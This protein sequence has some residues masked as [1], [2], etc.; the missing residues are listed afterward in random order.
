[1]GAMTLVARVTFLVLVG[2][3]FAAFFVAQRLKSAPPV[4]DVNSLAQ[5]LLAQRRRQARRATTSAVVL[6]VA[7]DVDG[8][9][10]QPRRRPGPAARRRRPVARLP[11]AAAATGTAR[12]TTAAARPTASTGCAS[13]CATRAARRSSQQ[14]MNVDTRAPRSEVCIGFRCND[15]RKRM[16]N[17]ISQGDRPVKIYIKGVSPRYATQFRVLRTDDGKPREV[18]RFELRGGRAPH[19][20]GRAASTASRSP[21]GTYIVQSEVRDTAGNVGVTP[22]VLEVGADIP[23]RPGLTVRGI[24]AQPPLRPVTAGSRVEFRVDARGA[25][26]R[27]R[28]RRVGRLGGAQAR[29]GETDPLLAF[30]APEGAVGRLPARAA[31]RAAGTRPCRSSSRRRARS[32]MLVV[33]PTISWLGHRQGRRPAVRR[34]PELAGRRRHGAL[35]ARVRRRGRAAGRVR[36][37]RRAAARLPRPPADPL[38]PDER[39]RPR[40]HAQPARQRPRGRAAARL[41]ALGDAHARPPPA[42]LR[43]RRR[44]PGRDR[45]RQP[46]PRRAAARARVRGRPGR[47]RAPRSRPRPTRSARASRACARRR[48]RSRSASTRAARRTG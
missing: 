26:Y 33:V 30:R 25:P 10:R 20:L 5:L 28:V 21:P 8:R 46:A 29:H 45:R 41:A 1:M 23:G 34:L 3:T 4:I 32:S 2:A 9:R 14:T 7:D 27:W 38:R 15:P 17:I 35:A 13:R 39:P 24:A 42:P 40:A 22:A 43:Q 6:K 48:S 44:A 31:L 47:C 11:A 18:T 37:R 19:G 12:P 36:R 16:G